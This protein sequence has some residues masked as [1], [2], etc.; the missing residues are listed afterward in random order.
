MM[1]KL[2]TLFVLSQFL[3]V[4]IQSCFATQGIQHA[5]APEVKSRLDLIESRIQARLENM[6]EH[7]QLKLAHRLY[8]L[9][10]RLRNKAHTLNDD[11]ITRAANGEATLNE[12]FS[13]NDEAI[14]NEAKDLEF[15]SDV[16]NEP[17]PQLEKHQVSGTDVKKNVD[18]LLVSL[19]SETDEQGFLSRASFEGFKEKL[20]GLQEKSLREPAGLGRLLVKIILS[21][22]IIMMALSVI[23]AMLSYIIGY[24]LIGLFIGG[25]WLYLV[26]AGAVVSI[27][28]TVRIFIRVGR[29]TSPLTGLPLL[30]A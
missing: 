16:G 11:Q 29:T 20:F 22:L 28:L 12:S 8:K 6:G 2:F 30:Q 13:K 27:L 15:I 18:P 3:N 10:V 17:L 23:T 1:K 4:Q 9:D 19:G 5:L 25:G 26:M 14:L 24:A 21:L 7:T